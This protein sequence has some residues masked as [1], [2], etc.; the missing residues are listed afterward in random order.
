MG[1]RELIS[2]YGPSAYRGSE[3]ADSAPERL[4]GQFHLP[5]EGLIEGSDPTL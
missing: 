5:Q 2:E 1:V 3:R 4:I